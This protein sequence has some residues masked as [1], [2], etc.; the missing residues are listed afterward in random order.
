MGITRSRTFMTTQQ[1]TTIHG[2]LMEIFGLGLL[3]VGESGIGKSE[4]A[5]GLISRGHRLVA[6]DA[7]TISVDEYQALTGSC[8]ELLKDFLE[9]RGLGILNIRNM[10][11]ETAVKDQVSLDLIVKLIDINDSIIIESNRLLGIHSEQIILGIAVPEVTIPIGP[12]RNISV[13]IESAVRNHKSKLKGYHAAE[14]FLERQKNYLES[15]SK[16]R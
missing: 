11:G 12:G 7:V 3:L 6:D 10:F 1:S 9:V 4:I 16:A 13:L 14:D 8:P 2:V 5:L 15:K